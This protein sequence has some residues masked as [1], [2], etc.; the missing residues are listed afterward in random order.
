MALVNIFSKAI[1]FEEFSIVPGL[2]LSLR[3]V[4]NRKSNILT[5]GGKKSYT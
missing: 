2:Y 5:R 4:N 1:F 3:N